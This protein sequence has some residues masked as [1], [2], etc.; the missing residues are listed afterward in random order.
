MLQAD[1]SGKLGLTEFHIL[2][3]KIKRYLVRSTTEGSDGVRRL[4]ID[5]A[6]RYNLCLPPV[7]FE[8]WPVEALFPCCLFTS[9]THFSAFPIVHAAVARTY[10]GSLTWTNRAAW[11][12]TRWGWLLNLQ[13]VL[14]VLLKWGE[15]KQ[16]SW[17]CCVS[18]VSFFVPV[19]RVQAEQQP[20]PADHPALHGGRHERRLWQLCHVSGQTGDHVQWVSP[21]FSSVKEQCVCACCLHT[22]I[23][24]PAAGCL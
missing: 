16:P 6:S 22:S 18:G 19:S 1:G 15:K 9:I 17:V 11:A 23:G 3:E 4:N 2:W 10:S 14:G 13:V 5:S 24:F 20:V 12:P 8:V 7:Y 21:A